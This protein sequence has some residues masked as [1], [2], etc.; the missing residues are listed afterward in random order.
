MI[1][2]YD[3][4]TGALLGQ[5]SEQQLQFLM[6]QLEEEYQEDQDYAFTG[7]TIDY[8]QGQGAGQDLVSLLRRAL[9]DKD[10]I[11]I[12]WSPS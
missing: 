2:L 1:N 4:K 12:R 5:I 10:E 3:T 6:D 7:M 11:S 8:L 9:G